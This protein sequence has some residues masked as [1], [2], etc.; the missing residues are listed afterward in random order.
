MV[1]VSVFRRHRG[2]GSGGSVDRNRI[3][4]RSKPSFVETERE[5]TGFDSTVHRGE[6]V[7]TATASPTKTTT[8]IIIIPIYTIYTMLAND[9]LCPLYQPSA[10][11][12]LC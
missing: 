5:K 8:I 6:K 2:I 3:R 12:A 1:S 10:G 4:I 7:L 11:T 9:G